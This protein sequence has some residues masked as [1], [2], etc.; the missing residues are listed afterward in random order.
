MELEDLIMVN[1]GNTPALENIP[2]PDDVNASDALLNRVILVF[3]VENQWV[4]WLL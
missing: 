4:V 1:D 2:T 3:V